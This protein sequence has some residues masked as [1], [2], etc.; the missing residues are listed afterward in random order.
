MFTQIIEYQ[1]QHMDKNDTA[2][3]ALTESGVGLI[4]TTCVKM[5]SYLRTIIRLSIRVAPLVIAH[6]A[7]V[8]D[9]CLIC[10][11]SIIDC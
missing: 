7:C 3:E 2:D 8:S 6:H 11:D 1:K 5:S 4:D 9:V 10:L